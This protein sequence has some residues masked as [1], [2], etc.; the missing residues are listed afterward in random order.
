MSNKFERD[1]PDS[2]APRDLDDQDSATS[3]S[4]QPASA[5]PSSE[6]PDLELLVQENLP[7]LRGWLGARLRGHRRQDIDD[8]CQDIMLKAIRG[9]RKLREIERFSAWLFR[10]ANNCLRDYLRQQQRRTK[11]VMGLELDLSEAVAENLRPDQDDEIQRLLRA[12]LALPEKFREPLILRHVQDLSYDEISEILGITKNNVQV[13]IFRG[14]Q[15]LKQSLGE[16]NSSSEDD[17]EEEDAKFQPSSS[18][19]EGSDGAS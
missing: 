5:V 13:R 9:V 17:S 12:V 18:A 6:K 14:R 15:L 19:S 4:A 2:Q 11:E 16:L 1:L 3:N 8:L 10:I 7:W